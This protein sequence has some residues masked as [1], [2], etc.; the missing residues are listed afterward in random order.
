MQTPGRLVVVT[1]ALAFALFLGTSCGGGTSRDTPVEEADESTLALGQSLYAANCATCHG[2][3]GTGQPGWQ[4]LQEDRT[5]PAPPHDSSGHTWHH[6][7]RVLLD[8]ITRGGQAAYGDQGFRSAMPA[9]GEQL[10]EE[11]IVA[12]LAYIKTFGTSPSGNSR[13]RSTRSRRD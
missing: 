5:Y 10:S 3:D 7:D 1:A 12:V 6:S 13:Q 8:I 2:A 9:W 11:E 4:S